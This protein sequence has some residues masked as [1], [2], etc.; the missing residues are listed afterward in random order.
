[1]VLFAAVH[2]SLP[3]TSETSR[4]DPAKSASRVK[5]V[6]R[7]TTGGFRRRP[8]ELPLWWLAN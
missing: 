2:M 3:G 1:M 5:A 8:L 6:V 7:R 4:R